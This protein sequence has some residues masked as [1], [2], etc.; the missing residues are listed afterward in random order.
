MT[1]AGLMYLVTRPSSPA[2]R[3]TAENPRVASLMGVK[4]DFGHLRTFVIG[5]ALAAL[6]GVMYAANYG[7]VQH[8]M[9][10]LPG[11]KA[12]TRRCSAA[13]ATSPA[14]WSAVCCWVSS[15]RSARLHRRLHARHSRQPLQGHLRLRGL[16]VILTL[17]PQGLLGERVAD[18]A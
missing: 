1:L 7:T 16:I 11:L 5:A 13:S 15:R 10:F 17:R 14:P 8:D 9:G 4:P 12:F 3:A 18:R 6:A 2:M